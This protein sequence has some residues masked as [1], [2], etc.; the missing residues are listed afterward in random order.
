M[1]PEFRDGSQ[2]HWGGEE[3]RKGPG[4]SGTEVSIHW[5]SLAKAVTTERFRVIDHGLNLPF[6]FKSPLQAPLPRLAHKRHNFN[7]PA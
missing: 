5:P 3:R 2:F 7:D 6:P 1:A 4:R